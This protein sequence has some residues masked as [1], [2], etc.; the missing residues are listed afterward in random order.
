V[1]TAIRIELLILIRPFITAGRGLAP[2]N[3]PRFLVNYL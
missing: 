2:G 1:L 3:H